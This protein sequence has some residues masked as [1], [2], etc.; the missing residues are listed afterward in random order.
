MEQQNYYLLLELPYDPPEHN[1]DNIKKAIQKKRSLWTRR[2]SNAKY[3]SEAE[4]FLRLIERMDEDLKDHSFREAEA[5]SA[6]ELKD[7]E[8]KQKEKEKYEKLDEIILI[9]SKKGYILE[10][11]IDRIQKDFGF[12]Q[13]EINTKIVSVPIKKN[14]SGAKRKSTTNGRPSLTKEKMKSICDLLDKLI[15]EP[16]VGKVAT[17][18]DLLE[19]SE[20]TGE[21]ELYDKA[22]KEYRLLSSKGAVSGELLSKKDAL[23]QALT[24]FKDE[25]TRL[26]YDESLRMKRFEKVAEYIKVAGCTGELEKS[27]YEELKT[28]AMNEGLPL[29]DAEMRIKR[30]CDEENVS[31]ITKQQQENKPKVEI[32]QCGYC[33]LVNKAKGVSCTGCGQPLKVTCKKC[34]ATFPSSSKHCSNCGISHVAVY[35]QDQYLKRAEWS[36][37]NKD[38]I[39]AQ[40]MVEKAKYYWNGRDDIKALSNKIDNV[41]KQIE[42][43]TQKIEEFMKDAKFYSAERELTGLKRLNPYL[44]TIPAMERNISRQ[45]NSAE[46]LL[47]KAKV[48]ST[49]K[50]KLSF[51]HSSLEESADC[52]AALTELSKFPPEPPKEVRAGITQ[53]AIKLEWNTPYKKEDVTYEIYRQEGSQPANKIADT[54]NCTFVDKKAEAGKRYCYYIQT[55]RGSKVSA[56]S[57]ITG[58]L[59]RTAEVD[60]LRAEVHEE[61]IQLSWKSPGKTKIEIWRK[62]GSLPQGRGD[63]MK[64]NG[65]KQQDVLD[66]NVEKDK[67]YGY[68]VLVQYEDQQGRP[69]FSKGVSIMS[70]HTTA[71]IGNI[72]VDEQKDMINFNWTPPA[73]GNVKLF[74]S[75]F[76]FDK[77][78]PNECWSYSTIAREAGNELVDSVSEGNASKVRNFSGILHVL[79]VLKIGNCAVIGESFV[80]QS[81][82]PV[83]KVVGKREENDLILQWKWPEDT[84]KVTIRYSEKSFQDPAA[85]ERECS[86]FSYENFNGYKIDSINEK[87]DIFVTLFIT[88]EW[89]GEKYYSKPVQYLYTEREPMEIR[90]SI[91]VQRKMLGL[92]KEA[93]LKIKVP[94]HGIPNLTLVKQK[95]RIPNRKSDGEIIGRIE[96][97]EDPSQG[98]IVKVLND[99]LEEDCYA[100]LFFELK[101]DAN[102]YKIV[103]EPGTKFSLFS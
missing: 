34:N 83:S 93:L 2:L 102:N 39:T 97:P 67:E 58:S 35:F 20:S 14:K 23:S 64:V 88:E 11:E 82:Q 70:V 73:V 5:R 32:E 84:Q 99:Y 75:D 95:G 100:K 63:G 21:K 66:K 60:S 89:D 33:G 68:L 30:V 85:E 22:N 16:R 62:E 46:A 1:Y 19:L 94:K 59:M 18:Y 50:E 65:V 56:K 51:L 81:V 7:K 49:D 76:P 41:F 96:S 6:K 25:E 29:A 55:K 71:A 98:Y 53:E 69:F 44:E 101:D 74:Y 45:I 57:S 13:S 79:P 80:L 78:K 17:L 8:T 87:Q 3:R 24:V 27:V 61:G 37:M 9:L 91:A 86:R 42:Q 90:Y 36:L 72:S 38:Y 103:A 47:T 54:V 28:Q 43:Q 26:K 15:E 92:K 12:T 77:Y 4:E 31:I 40:E 52:T 48:A 10:D